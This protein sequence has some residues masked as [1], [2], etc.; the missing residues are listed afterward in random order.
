MTTQSPALKC[1]FMDARDREANARV[2]ARRFHACPSQGPSPRKNTWPAARRSRN[3][4][5]DGRGSRRRG[6]PVKRGNQ[7][8][9]FLR[10]LAA[11]SALAHSLP[12]PSPF[13]RK[14]A[15]SSLKLPADILPGAHRRRR[16]S[17]PSA[18]TRNTCPPGADCG[19][20]APP[21]FGLFRFFRPP[22]WIGRKTAKEGEKTR[23]CG[24]GG[25]VAVGGRRAFGALSV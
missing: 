12:S 20:A 16:G 17:L 22:V 9:V 7:F 6:A 18:V 1:G 10:L 14:K 15:Q 8:P 21:L 13:C 24:S 23:P 25:A 19:F 11:N 5:G 2:V 3:R 4:M